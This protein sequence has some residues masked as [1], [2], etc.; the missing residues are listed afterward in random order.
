MK[1]REILAVI[2]ARGGSKRLPHKNIKPLLGKPLIYWTI[3]SAIESKCFSKVMVS[4]D[5]RKISDVSKE[6]GAEVPYIRNNE[7]ASDTATSVDVVIDVIEYY[8][9]QGVFFDYVML[10][11]PTSPLRRVTDISRAI[12]MLNDSYD[13]KSVVSM[14][15]CEHSP[16]WSAKISKSGKLETFIGEGSVGKRSQ[17][18][19]TY[20]RVNGAI[21]LISTQVIFKERSFFI[22]DKTY[23][24]IMEN[25][26]SIDIDEEIDFKIAEM[27]M[28]F[29]Y[30]NK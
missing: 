29:R 12:D 16:L 28:N 19:E 20:Y 7:L 15:K 22:K 14:C 17:D 18:L 4:T 21:Y 8:K 23:S 25:E 24:Y 3:S 26:Y 2:P 30:E 13:D 9:Q 10:L 5:C 27:M 11:Q 6:F 1:R